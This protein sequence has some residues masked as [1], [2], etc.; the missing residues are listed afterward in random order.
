MLEYGYFNYYVVNMKIKKTHEYSTKIKFKKF[1]V[2]ILFYYLTLSLLGIE[3][4]SL[5]WFVF[6]RVNV[7]LNKDHNIGLILNFTS[8]YFLSYN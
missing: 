7:A 2:F 3:F 6:H 4:Y 5:F 1:K 8:I